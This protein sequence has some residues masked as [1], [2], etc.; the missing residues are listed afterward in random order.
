MCDELFIRFPP[1]CR[2][3]LHRQVVQLVPSCLCS[4]MFSVTCIIFLR[5]YNSSRWSLKETLMRHFPFPSSTLQSRN[6]FNSEILLNSWNDSTVLQIPSQQTSRL[7]IEIAFYKTQWLKSE[8]VKI[9]SR[10]SGDWIIQTRYVIHRS[11]SGYGAETMFS[12]AI[13][14]DT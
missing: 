12:L 1:R 14:C 4:K 8:T 7:R 5:F 3:R 11:K 9:M 13:T 6:P 2:Y 10:N